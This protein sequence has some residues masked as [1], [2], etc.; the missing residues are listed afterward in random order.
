[1]GAPAKPTGR[2][3]PLGLACG[4]L[5]P[6]LYA[7]TVAWGGTLFAGYD[8]LRDAISSLM[9][10]GRI[11]AGPLVLLFAL[12]NGLVVLF[13]LAGL[14]ATGRQA[15]WTAAFAVLLATGVSGGLILLFPMD[16]AGQPP[17]L[18]GIVHIVLSG[19]ASLGSM[20]AML[21]SALA[22]R[23]RPADG[24]LALFIGLDLVVVF[25]SGLLAAI[26]AAGSWPLMGLL[27]RVTIGAFQLWQLVAA[28]ALLVRLR[29]SHAL[30]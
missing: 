10:S 24:T 22:L 8:Q 12:Y 23:R 30:P 18:P 9:Q 4:V 25:A 19:L 26:A 15:M 2:L 6:L 14:V 20:G 1:M 28:S 13:A 17:T 3:L 16:P 29:P 21:L 11:G 5:A 27:E 7:G